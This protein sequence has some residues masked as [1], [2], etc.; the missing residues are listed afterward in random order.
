MEAIKLLTSIKCGGIKRLSKETLMIGEDISKE[1]ASYLVD[2]GVATY[3]VLES[4]TP[5]D[6][7]EPLEAM[8]REELHALCA[9]K[10]L[11][12]YARLRKEEVIAL[13]ERAQS[14]VVLDDLDENALR[15]LAKEEEIEIPEGVD[16]ETMRE[17]IAHE[18]GI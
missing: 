1:D 2:Q 15:E 17:L 14:E 8:S 3:C 7:P 9:K 5:L 13:L 11:R 12:G 16:V 4:E 10:G 6:V 18:L